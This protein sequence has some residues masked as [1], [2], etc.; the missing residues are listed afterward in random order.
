ME[1]EYNPQILGPIIGGAISAV[2]YVLVTRWL[3]KKA[4][5]RENR[6]KA[7][8]ELKKH[9]NNLVKGII[10]PLSQNSGGIVVSEFGYIS[11]V[12]YYAEIDESQL[13]IIQAHYPD[14]W[15]TWQELERK[16]QNHWNKIDILQKGI[17]ELVKTKL[18]QYKITLPIKSFSIR[19]ELI[20]GGIYLD[21]L[22]TLNDQARDYPISPDFSKVVIKED[23]GFYTLEDSASKYASSQNRAP[24][25]K[26]K[27][28]LVE[29]QTNQNLVEK[30]LTLTKEAGKIIKQYQGFHSDLE[31]I[32]K[33]GL[34]I[35]NPKFEPVK[36]C[37]V[38][39]DIFF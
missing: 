26:C 12:A 17:G 3:N 9:F 34:F 38:C 29:I 31:R 23:S 1:I 36:S 30:T 2:V 4:G 10:T 14:L 11:S 19:Q 15:R 39:K 32:R 21:L 22:K 35:S 25:E 24:I 33:R 5:E 8:A 13:S 20:S 27:L 37:P 28:V 6:R 7:E 16:R 18:T